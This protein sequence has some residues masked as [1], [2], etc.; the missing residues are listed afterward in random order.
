MYRRY[1]ESQYARRKCTVIHLFQKGGK[2]KKDGGSEKGRKKKK[3]VRKRENMWSRRLVPVP[4]DANQISRCSILVDDLLVD[5]GRNMDET[6]PLRLG[7]NS[8]TV[9]SQIQVEAYIL[10]LNRY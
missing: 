4:Y 1:R 8:S 10:T 7:G 5:L 3:E 2:A 6:E 9:F